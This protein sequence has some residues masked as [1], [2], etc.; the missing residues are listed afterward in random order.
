MQ[1]RE[2]IITDNWDECFICG[3]QYL[4]QEHHCLHG[5]YRKLADKYHIVVP[6]C[7]FCH[8]KLH[9]HGFRDKELQALGQEK[10]EEHYP[11]L[12]FREIFGR[13]FK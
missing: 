8:D 5:S 12:N 9:D 4:L 1:K 7:W 11:D 10:F 13:N 6:L 3:S 2:S